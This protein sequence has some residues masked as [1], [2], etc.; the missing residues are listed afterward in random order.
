MTEKEIEDVQPLS[1]KA[2][3]KKHGETGGL[4]T[5]VSRQ[6]WYSRI[7]IIVLLIIIAAMSALH[8]LRPV[9]ILTIN[10][11][12]EIIAR[13]DYLDK[14]SRSDSEIVASSKRFMS[15]FLSADS[16]TIFEDAE[17]VLNAMC[18][19]LKQSTYE[20][21]A[22][23]NYLGTIENAG[24]TSRVIFNDEESNYYPDDSGEF[25]VIELVG[26]VIIGGTTPSDFAT[27][28]SYKVSPRI[29]ENTLGITICSI[30]DI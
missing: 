20:G 30:E 21:W 3:L 6:I 17:L 15:A 22:K 27:K 12:G 19:E 1:D 18:P 13:L 8:A 10:E 14:T 5:M 9:P 25:G 23:T 11:A 2:L 4:I 24:L 16:Q 29:P 26:Q 7:F 28:L